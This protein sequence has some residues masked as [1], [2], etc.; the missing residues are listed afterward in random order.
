MLA[1]SDMHPANGGFTTGQGGQSARALPQSGCDN[2][3]L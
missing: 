3:L 1:G 2:G